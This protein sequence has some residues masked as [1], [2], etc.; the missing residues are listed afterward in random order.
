MPSR[1]KRFLIAGLIATAVAIVLV[2][3]ETVFRPG[4]SIQATLGDGLRRVT[5]LQAGAG[6]FKY[7]SDSRITGW[8]RSWL[9]NALAAKLPPLTSFSST[10][11]NGRN[12]SP[13]LSL[14][15]KFERVV[16]GQV[17]PTSNVEQAFSR[18]EFEESTGFTFSQLAGSSS[19][20]NNLVAFHVD[21]FPRRDRTLHVRAFERGTEKPLFDFIIPNPGW[22]ET[23]PEW[24]PESIPI[25]QTDDPVTATL[26]GV[27]MRSYENGGSYLTADVETRSSDPAWRKNHFDYW[28]EDSTGNCDAVLSPFEPAIRVHVLVRRD[29]DAEFTASEAWS[30][31]ALALAAP[32]SMRKIDQKRVLD[33]IS[34]NVRYLS[35]AGCVLEEGGQI[36][37]SAPSWPGQSGTSTSNGT[38][39]RNGKQV[40]YT[41]VDCGVPFFRVDMSPL[42]PNTELLTLV[43][44]QNGKALKQHN[45][46]TTHGF[47]GGSFRLVQF[48]PEPETETVSLKII[49]N[50]A[51]AFEFTVAPPGGVSRP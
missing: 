7:S 26:R 24:R 15:F 48:D 46:G 16:D 36:T 42:P 30:L 45:T 50:R 20:S 32:E 23:F 18:F 40:S 34:I 8:L 37:V 6:A 49:V 1:R 19:S 10:G 44:D 28:F 3:R 43:A 9:P 51:R 17:V 29:E 21:S 47:S 35:S 25:S 13:Q 22:S 38:N 33:G 12:G 41:R 39:F 14:L 2:V 4:E 31:P 27:A 11:N 5:F